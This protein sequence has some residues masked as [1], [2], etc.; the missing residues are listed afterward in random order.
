MQ[1]FGHNYIII[2]NEL[3]R[4]TLKTTIWAHEQKISSELYKFQR[5]WHAVNFVKLAMDYSVDT[6]SSPGVL[7]SIVHGSLGVEGLMRMG[8]RT[9]PHPNHQPSRSLF[10]RLTHR[11][12]DRRLGTCQVPN[13]TLSCITKCPRKMRAESQVPPKM[14]LCLSLTSAK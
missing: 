8:R 4:A 13:L 9:G 11:P 1:N 12:A 2:C 7:F 6:A 14:D 5:A 10:S 3:F